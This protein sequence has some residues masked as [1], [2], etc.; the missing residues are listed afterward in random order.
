M[1]TPTKTQG[2]SLLAM[3]NLANATF[4]VSAAQSVTTKFYAQIFIHIGR[5]ATAA[6]TLPINIRIMGS[7]KSSGDDQWF[8]LAKFQTGVAA[9]LSKTMA[10]S[11]NNAGVTTLT[12]TA[13]WDAATDGDFIFIKNAT[14][15]I[16]EFVRG[17]IHTTTAM[18][19]MDATTNA[20]N[21]S[22]S[23]DHA[24]EFVAILDLRS[25]G[26]I[27]VEVDTI[28]TGQACNVEAFMCTCDSIG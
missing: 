17:G 7:A 10:A 4:L 27:R 26:R 21:S 13:N 1:A 18:P 11:G 28:G 14:I 16:S 23:F 8:T 5:D 22:T 12:A 24:E 15:G 2:T 9:C 6:L 20:Q 3:Q 19:L 25:I